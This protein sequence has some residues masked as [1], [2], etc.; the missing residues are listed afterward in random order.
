[1]ELEKRYTIKDLVAKRNRILELY[2]IIDKA[3]DELDEI[4][5]PVTYLMSYDLDRKEQIRNADD[6]RRKVDGKFWMYVA[7]TSKLSNALSEKAKWDLWEKCEKEPDEFTSVNVE[8]YVENFSKIYAENYLQTVK[9]VFRNLIA[10]Q[11]NGS[12]NCRSK[13]NNLRRVEKSFRTRYAMYSGWQGEWHAGSYYGRS[14]ILEDLLTAC[15]LLE[16]GIRPNYAET[17]QSLVQAQKQNDIYCNEFESPFFTVKCFKN[18]NQ[19]IRWKEDKLDVLDDL[20]RY[21]SG[22][23]D[24]P[25]PL[26]K[27]YKPEHFE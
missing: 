15:Y 24:L 4:C 25:D 27:R 10:C 7:N 21:G 23:K 19:L 3:K 16:S 11:Y 26:K 9:E 6:W 17:W 5:E 12:S 22:N 1:M 8:L 18:G 13:T 2:R 14:D 20:N